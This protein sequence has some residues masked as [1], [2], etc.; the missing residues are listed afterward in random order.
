[1][2]CELDNFTFKMLHWI[3]LH[4][5]HVKA[6]QIYNTFTVPCKKSKIVSFAFSKMQNIVVFPFCSRF[7]V[8]LT[9]SNAF[10]SAS[11]AFCLLSPIWPR[12]F[13]STT[14]RGGHESFPHLKLDLLKL[15]HEKW[16]AY[17]LTYCKLIH[18][19]FGA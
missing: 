13:W 1:M 6:K 15:G 11:S 19:L 10:G 7:S 2:S 8:K 3:I 14:A 9:F 17:S 4:L 5:H 12:P 16:Y 18:I